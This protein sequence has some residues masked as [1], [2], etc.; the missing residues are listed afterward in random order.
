MLIYWF[1]LVFGL[2]AIVGSFLNVCIARL[3][4]E[5]S[6]LWPGSRCGHCYQRIRLYDNIPLI[7]YWLLRGRCRTCH[8]RFSS[9]YFWIELLTACSFVA[10]FYLEVV[11][12]IH[13]FPIF[14]ERSLYIRY[15]DIPW[16]GW[17]MFLFHTVFLLSFLIAAAFCDLDRREIPLAITLTGTLVGLVGAVLWPWPWPSTP[18]LALPKTAVDPWWMIDPQLGPKEGL[19]PWPVWGP[20]P[21]WLPPGSWQ[22]GL[23]T[24]LAGAL[25]GMF[26][27][28]AIRFLFSRG[29]G[30]EAL[31]LGDADLM[32]MAGSFL[33]CQVVVV[34]FFVSTGPALVFGIIQLVVYRDNSLPF[35]PSLAVGVIITWLCWAQIGP[36]VQVLLFNGTLVIAL[37][38]VCAV[39]MLVASYLIRLAKQSRQT[40]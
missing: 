15:G 28:R 13:D 24:G 8:A 31:G 7:S 36:F 2:G 19:Y 32:M 33:G 27:L 22:L 34:A 14:K 25:V 17:I 9:R 39:F 5:K 26:M 40:G 21:T 23:A 10:V 16:Q 20:L 29:L 30:I 3:P 11:Y 18:S 1:F 35:G 38:A 4:L 12:N 37:A 6:V